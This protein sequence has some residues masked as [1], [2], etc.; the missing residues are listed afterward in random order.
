ARARL[1]ELGAAGVTD[2]VL[3]PVGPDPLGALGSL[4]GVV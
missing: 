1:G 2:A 3:A 4:A